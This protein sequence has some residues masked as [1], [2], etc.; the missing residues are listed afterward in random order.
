MRTA[1]PGPFELRGTVREVFEAL[2]ERGGLRAIFH[3]QFL[4]VGPA[5]AF[6]TSNP[7]LLTALDTLSFETGS[8]W[9]PQDA[10]TILVG[11]D[12]PTI[13]R[14]IEPVIAKMIDFTHIQ[15]PDDVRDIGTM[16]RTILSFNVI[17]DLPHG[18]SVSD[19]AEKVALAERI[20]ATLD[21]PSRRAAP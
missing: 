7:G 4:Q 3:P 17:T 1:S 13:R 5:I 10:H 11:A 9:L 8:F 6:K 18:L 2:A 15:T 21:I 19:T 12:N 16:L 20:V 14:Q